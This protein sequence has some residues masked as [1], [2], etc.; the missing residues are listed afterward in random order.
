MLLSFAQFERE[1]TGERIRDKVA[2]SKKRGIWMGGAVPLGYRV[3]NRALHIVE[4]HA[5]FVR[6]LF[7]RYL[8]IGSVVRLK[9]ALDTG[10]HSLAGSCC[11]HLGKSTCGWRTHQSR[12]HLPDPIELFLRSGRLPATKANFPMAYT[13]QSSIRV[14]GTAS[15][16]SS[17]NKRNQ[18]RIPIAILESFL[19][20]NLYDDR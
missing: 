7:R 5:D 2:A 17:W 12:A 18:G 13:L 11:W 20:G 19:A 10:E 16:S 4:E 8:E 14:L 6:M 9:A 3:E 15:N 1:I